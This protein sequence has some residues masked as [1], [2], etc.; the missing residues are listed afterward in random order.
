MVCP[1]IKLLTS[2]VIL[3]LSSGGCA[4][5]PHAEGPGPGAYCDLYTPV[6]QQKGDAA[7]ALKAPP[8]PLRRILL[9]EKL[10]RTC[11]KPG[12]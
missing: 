9:N 3:S 1:T 11:P 5:F 7:I 10:Y 4:L 2:S 8:G 6:I 12:S